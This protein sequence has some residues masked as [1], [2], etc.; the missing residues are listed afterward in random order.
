MAGARTTTVRDL[1]TSNRSRALWEIFLHGP[2]TRQDVGREAELSAATVSNLVAALEAEGV[3]AEVGLE[4]S[5]G[6]RPRGLLQVNPGFGY[7]IGVDVGESAVLVELFDF[8]LAPRASHASAAGASGLGPLDAAERISGGIET[9]IAGAGVARADILG[10]GVAVPGIVEHAERAVVHG[11]SAGWDAVP[12]EAMLPERLALP[13]DVDNAAVALGQ[14]E[15]MFG[16][17]R[18]TDN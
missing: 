4:D 13:V 6:G 5:N 14:A 3:V 10:V 9:V 7:V 18:V 8:A 12:L 1:R 17:A 15:K 16:A 2:L 11:Q